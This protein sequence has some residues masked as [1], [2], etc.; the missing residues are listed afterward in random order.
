[1][2]E[3]VDLVWS[4]MADD[5]QGTQRRQELADAMLAIGGGRDSW[6]TDGQAAAGQR[7]MMALAGPPARRKPKPPPEEPSPQ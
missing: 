4:Y 2:R 6:G 3:W 7:A 1:M 5:A